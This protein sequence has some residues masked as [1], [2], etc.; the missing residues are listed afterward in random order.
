[1]PTK[2]GSVTTRAMGPEPKQFWMAGAK[3]FLMVEPEPEI[4][5]PVPQV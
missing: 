2:P 1:M 4:W 3:N 5:V